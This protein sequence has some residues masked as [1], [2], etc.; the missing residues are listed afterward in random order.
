MV[1]V[2]SQ[3]FKGIWEGIFEKAQD[4]LWREMS[5]QN[6]QLT[7][8]SDEYLKQLALLLR[9]LRVR[10][11]GKDFYLFLEDALEMR[12]L[13]Q[14]FHGELADFMMKPAPN[15]L[16]LAPRGHLKSTII[17]FG[18]ALWELTKNPDLRILIANYKLENA[19]SFLQQI[20]NV[21]SM[22]EAF[23]FFYSPIIPD[24]KKTRWNESQILIRRNKNM[25]EASVEVTGVGGEI[26]GKHF[27]LIIYDDVVGPENISTLEQVQKLRTWFNQMQAILEP[28]GKQVL[29]G[30]RWHFADLYGF[31][32]ENL[33][34]Q[35]AVYHRG[36]YDPEGNP[37]WPE[38]FTKE[39]VENIKK[40]MEAD[41]NSGR[42]MFV[43]QYLNQ[44]IDE[45]NASFKRSKMRFFTLG[46]EPQ[47]LAVSIAV[48]PA[49]SEKES[50]D[51]TAFTIRGVD[52]EGKWWILE[53]IARRGMTPTEVVDTIFELYARYSQKYSVDAVGIEAQAYQKS[54]IYAMQDEMKKRNVYFNLVELGN[55]RNSKELRI[56]A[57]IPRYD[58]GMLMFRKPGTGDDSEI[59]VDELLRFPKSPHDDCSDSLSFHLNLEVEPNFVPSVN[60]SEDS[61]ALNG[62]D[63][64]GYPVEE[65]SGAGIGIFF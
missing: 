10:L 45:E 50:A 17:T 16:V 27:D 34:D 23:T 57:L 24:L 28:D 19:K 3:K 42:Q 4:E 20:K 60:Q 5:A 33:G 46:E 54:L 49:I 58:L 38:K 61:D 62:R 48:D 2:E 1:P 64:Y 53:T 37:V 6:P 9:D 13:S 8:K 47:T 51:R 36:V 32:M 40:R 43:A 11:H 25:K 55:W 15:K 21:F 63:R 22:G 56:K 31:I 14:S 12:G 18:Y 59:L 26:T 30:T 7:K 52:T 35:Y 44:V 29:V 39:R 65:T 41:P